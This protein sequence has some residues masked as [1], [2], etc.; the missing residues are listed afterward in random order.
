MSSAVK[1]V[2]F[3]EFTASWLATWAAVKLKASAFREYE[4]V[5]SRHL[6]PA[7]GDLPITDVTTERIQVYVADRIASGLA[8]RSVDNHTIVLKAILGTAVDYGL[9]L[10]NPVDKVARPRAERTEMR[11]L[12]PPEL[13]QLI[14]ATEPSWRLLIAFAG[15]CGL[16][17]GE[18]KAL[19]WSDID[20]DPMTL[21]ITKSMR[22]G[23]VSAVK[24]SSSKSTVALPES[25]LPLIEQRRRQ[26]GG[27]KLVF[28]KRDGSPISD[29]TP[30]RILN[31]ALVAAHLPAMR[32]HNLRH[33]WAVAHLR[34]GTDVRT[35]A[36]LG[37]WSSPSTLVETYSHVIGIGGDAVRRFD[38]YM[39]SPE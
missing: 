32:F 13:Q 3:R 38:E 6:V 35:L 16:R 9:L 26:A 5:A 15:L 29:S 17:V 34:A 30:A 33:S 23:V 28:C 21:S 31:R 27:H 18:I 1:P 11:F 39:R 8:P 36:A 20:T 2:R 37:R 12:T 4:S 10:E 22:A 24:T 19:E 7:L 14:E 25:L